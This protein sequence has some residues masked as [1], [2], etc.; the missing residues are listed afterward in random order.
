M[1]R[2]STEWGMVI[3]LVL[4][5]AIGLVSI[6]YRCSALLSRAALSGKWPV[7]ARRRRA[8]LFVQ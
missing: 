3:S 5:V 6:D 2:A 8:A 4:L 7:R 1:K